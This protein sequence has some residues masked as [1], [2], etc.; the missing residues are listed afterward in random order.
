MASLQ[1]V[2]PYLRQLRRRAGLSQ[3]EAARLLGVTASSL[4]QIETG[5]RQP[6]LRRMRQLASIYGVEPAVVLREAGLVELDWMAL[7]QGPARDAGQEPVPEDPLASLTPEEREEMLA[8]LAFLR[9]RAS[10]R[11]A[12]A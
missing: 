1:P 12:R 3:K 7:L 8:Y 4:C 6:S 5:R 2:G 9:F 10:L 11:R